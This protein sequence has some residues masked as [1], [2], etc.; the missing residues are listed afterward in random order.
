MRARADERK[1][2]FKEYNYKFTNNRH[3]IDEIEKKPAYK[4][5]GIELD[6]TTEESKLSKTSV[7]IDSNDEVQLRSNN[8][9][10]HDNV[11]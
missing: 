1:R 3:N 2:T 5:A 7:S 4:R 6:E 9:F 10:L 11:D 8:S